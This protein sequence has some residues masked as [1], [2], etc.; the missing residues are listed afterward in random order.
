MTKEVKSTSCSGRPV[1]QSNSLRTGSSRQDVQTPL[2]P[3]HRKRTCFS[4]R[5]ETENICCKVRWDKTMVS[6]RVSMR[7]NNT[8]QVLPVSYLNLLAVN[9]NH[10]DSV[11]ISHPHVTTFCKAATNR[12]QGVWSKWHHWV[13]LQIPA[14]CQSQHS[15]PLSHQVLTQMLC[16][17]WKM[18]KH[19][20]W[21]RYKEQKENHYLNC[22]RKMLM[23]HQ[24]NQLWLDPENT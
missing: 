18:G 16:K 24:L 14:T 8:L 1:D 12:L 7:Q 5:S 22:V 9:V 23:S 13:W 3:A 19:I 20:S 10:V 2:P 11:P 21:D 15:L 4:L 17:A 6:R